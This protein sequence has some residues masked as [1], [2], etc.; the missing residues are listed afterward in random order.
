[1]KKIR[2]VLLSV[3]L[4]SSLTFS[5]FKKGDFELGL[6]LG[7]GSQ[8]YETD[9][10][11]GSQNTTTTYF[12]LA[13]APAYYIINGLAVE[14]ELGVN[15]IENTSAS[16]F[17]LPNIGFTHAVSK[18]VGLFVHAGYGVASGI[19][20]PNSAVLNR[21]TSDLD[22]KVINFGTGVKYLVGQNAF[23]KAELN[24]RRYAFDIKRS[25]YYSPAEQKYSLISL[26]I[27]LGILF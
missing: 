23:V 25:Y 18:N 6:N 12:I 19:P 20:V 22:V 17:L 8:N 26:N 14:L 10:G 16:Y 9:F 3:I 24:Y 13:A 27:G 21:V 1:M 7:L 5:Q 4:L 2:I 11:G 15:S